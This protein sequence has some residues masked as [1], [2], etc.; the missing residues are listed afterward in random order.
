[1]RMR[2]R[3][4]H[5]LKIVDGEVEVEVVHV[6]GEEVELAD[7]LWSER[8]PV[9]LRVLAEIESVLAHV[10]GDAV[11]D[12]AGEL[13]PEGSRIPVVTNRAV[14]RLPRLEL[15]RRSAVAPQHRLEPA[16]LSRRPQHLPL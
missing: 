13:V 6:A 8:R 5:L 10:V 11:I 3:L 12:L 9:A 1:M 14:H 7:E 16:E 2:R 15:I 4:E